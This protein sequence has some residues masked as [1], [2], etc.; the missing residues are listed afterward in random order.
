MRYFNTD[1]Y[2]MKWT[3]ALAFVFRTKLVPYNFFYRIDSRPISK[4]S[5]EWK[6]NKS[7]EAFFK[8]ILHNEESMALYWWLNNNNMHS[9]VLTKKNLF[10]KRFVMLL[11]SVRYKTLMKIKKVLYDWFQLFKSK[12]NQFIPS[13]LAQQIILSVSTGKIYLC[14]IFLRQKI[15]KQP[16]W[17][18]CF[19]FVLPTEDCKVFY[20]WM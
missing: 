11:E 13:W 1:R 18:F 14:P 17:Y 9:T 3:N 8:L 15:I 7:L 19:L 2:V 4:M 20:V 10:L 12:T 5:F 16:F 6:R